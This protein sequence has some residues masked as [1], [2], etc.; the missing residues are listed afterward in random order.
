MPEPISPVI[1][2]MSL[3]DEIAIT[4]IPINLQL[5]HVNSLLKWLA[6]IQEADNENVT[7]PTHWI[8]SL[9]PKWAMQ[10][11]YLFEEKIQ[12]LVH[13]QNFINDME[14]P[15]TE[16]MELIGDFSLFKELQ[17]AI[18]NLQQAYSEIPY[19]ETEVAM[20]SSECNILE[21]KELL[22]TLFYYLDK[23][24]TFV[25]KVDH[26]KQITLHAAI[27]L[28]SCFFFQQTEPPFY[29]PS[30]EYGEIAE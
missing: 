13:L 8:A 3:L 14:K 17:T 9:N 25:L 12:G 18:Y 22:P 26:L 29:L 7:H 2:H 30:N 23:V 10:T 28:A 15:L 20:L 4:L 11:N 1:P 21:Q 6:A 5:R 19:V 27:H 16:L 24:S